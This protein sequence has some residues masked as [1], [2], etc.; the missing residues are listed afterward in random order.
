MYFSC[1]APDKTAGKDAATNERPR[2]RAFLAA[3]TVSAVIASGAV[4]SG[5]VPD[6][7]LIPRPVPARAA[8]AMQPE[9]PA[10]QR[11]GPAPAD[12]KVSAT[13]AETRLALESAPQGQ[14]LPAPEAA[15]KMRQAETAE[16]SRIVKAVAPHKKHPRVRPNS[17]ASEQQSPA[18]SLPCSDDMRE[19]G[20]DCR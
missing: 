16:G 1:G 10:A 3:A 6:L 5:L 7:S 14:T 8:R 4:F 19:K 9:K 2:R 20:V 11:P 13:P 12:A 17:D 18:V 15:R